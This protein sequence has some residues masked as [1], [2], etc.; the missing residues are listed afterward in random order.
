ME[1]APVSF[2][3][4][5]LTE[6]LLHRKWRIMGSACAVSVLAGLVSFTL[7][8]RYLATGIMVVNPPASQEASPSERATDIDI[9][10]SP[11]LLKTVAAQL[12]LAGHGG[13]IPPSHLPAPLAHLTASVGAA[14]HGATAAILGKTPAADAGVSDPNEPVD[15]YLAGHVKVTGAEDSRALTISFDAADPHVAADVVNGVMNQYIDQGEATRRSTANSL[16]EAFLAQ[17]GTVR[18]QA[19]DAVRRVREF[20]QKHDVLAVEAG[21]TVNLQ[22]STQLAELS[23][24]KADLAQAQAAVAANHQRASADSQSS[25]VMQ[26][27]RQHETDVLQ[28]LAMASAYG[29]N[30]PKRIALEADL[31]SVR[32]QIAAETGKLSDALNRDLSVASMRVATLQQAVDHAQSR[33]QLSGDAQLQLAQLN[34]DVDTRHSEYQAL[35]LRAQQARSSAD[36]EASARIVSPAVPPHRP[37]PSRLPG[38]AVLGFITGLILSAAF[39]VVRTIFRAKV[40]STRGLES[41]TGLAN[42]GSLPFIASHA[43]FNM[44]DLTVLKPHSALSETLR[45][46]RVGTHTVG[47]SSQDGVLLV[48]STELGEGKSSTAAALARRAAADGLRVI[49]IEAD[50]HRPGVSKVLQ[51]QPVPS[52]ETVLQGRGGFWHILPTDPRS[53]LHCLLSD[54]SSANPYALLQ[55]PRFSALVAHARKAYDLVVIDS[56]PVLHVADPVLLSQFADTILFTVRADSTPIALVMEALH[57]FPREARAKVM[58]VLTHARVSRYHP[59]GS[60]HGYNPGEWQDE[61]QQGFP[62]RRIGELV[63]V[64]DGA[65]QRGHVSSAENRVG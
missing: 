39:I 6:L 14:L 44:V 58:T 21:S 25:P 59:Q 13:T 36:Q 2:D 7:P 46:L 30:Y 42:V 48:T 51:V 31:Q 63:R 32:R 29:P 57:R 15:D 50:M 3:A 10:R 62:L 53:G 49:F 56:P 19:D 16:A 52:L 45:G 47:G 28:Q 18:Q 65:T 40:V 12:D 26:S 35:L 43:D 38:L 33:A 11:A 1:T 61:A 55:S 8:T 41:A 24:A 27:L 60:Y 4:R 34:R 23:S 54:G 37:E 17:A 5:F 22:L 64:G 9:L 20:Q